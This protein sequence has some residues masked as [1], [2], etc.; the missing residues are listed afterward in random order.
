MGVVYNSILDELFVATRGQGATLNGRPIKASQTEA[1]GSAIF[2]TEIGVTRDEAT[3]G[4][5]FSRI[6]NLCQQVRQDQ[7]FS[8]RML[9]RRRGSTSSP[10]MT[11]AALADEVNAGSGQLCP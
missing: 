1:L 8:I 7:S 6:S 4:A 3:V 2:A 11:S 10:S 5:V 9:E